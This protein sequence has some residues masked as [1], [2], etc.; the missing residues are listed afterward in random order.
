MQEDIAVGSRSS[1][2]CGTLDVVQ[3]LGASTGD[4]RTAGRFSVGAIEAEEG[5]AP[6]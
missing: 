1:S 4:D 6:P 2:T 3:S 5:M